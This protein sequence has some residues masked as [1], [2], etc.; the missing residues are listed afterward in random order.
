VKPRN[1][2]PLHHHAGETGPWAEDTLRA[3]LQNLHGLDEFGVPADATLPRMLFIHEG[4]NHGQ[5]G[6]PG[7]VT[8]ARMA[9]D[10]LDGEG[11]SS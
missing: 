6:P 5:A 10:P 2:H 9:C 7:R 3:H 1:E 11:P 4:L 8:E